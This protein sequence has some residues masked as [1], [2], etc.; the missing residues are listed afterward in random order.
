MSIVPS[1]F[2]ATAPS[3]P[4][5]SVIA[6]PD[7][8]RS[9]TLD[10]DPP[11]PDEIN[12][13]IIQYVINVTVVGS[14]STFQLISNSSSI[15]VLDLKPYTTYICTIA[16]VTSVGI[17]PFSSPLPFSTPQDGKNYFIVY[18]YSIIIIIVIL[19]L[20]SSAYPSTS[21]YHT[22]LDKLHYC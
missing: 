9:A 2:S 11:P 7:S 14:S 1:F 5:T 6:Q 4:P 17:G 8:S 22:V 12:G 20:I 19:Y 21:E 13:I 15:F 10:W 18:N 16:A 3:A